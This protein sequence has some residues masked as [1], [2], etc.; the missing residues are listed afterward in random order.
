MSHESRKAGNSRMPRSVRVETAALQFSAA[1]FAISA[2]GEAEP[3]HGHDYQVHVD[4]WG[5]LNK[6]DFVVDFHHLTREARRIIEPL[7][8]KVLL[9]E[10]NPALGLNRTPTETRVEVGGRRWTFPSDD[11]RLLPVANTTTELLAEYL[12]KYILEELLENRLCP[13]LRS[14]EVRLSESAGF[15]ATAE[16]SFD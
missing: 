8:H 2:A 9:A 15:S 14:I 6:D 3:L 1:H 7:E 4:V 5:S 10:R 12:V 16:I 11:C 13:G